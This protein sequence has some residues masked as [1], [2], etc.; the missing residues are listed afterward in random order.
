M[1]PRDFILPVRPSR[2]R[3]DIGGSVFPS[4]GNNRQNSSAEVLPAGCFLLRPAAV[5]CP[6]DFPLPLPLALVT[7]L[8]PCWNVISAAN[9]GSRGVYFGFLLAPE[10]LLKM[11]VEVVHALLRQQASI[12]TA[13]DAESNVSEAFNG[14]EGTN[15]VVILR[16]LATRADEHPHV[17]VFVVDDAGHFPMSPVQH[18][19]H[20]GGIGD[21]LLIDDLDQLVQGP[22]AAPAVV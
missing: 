19:V 3:G 20:Q 4:F 8:P 1:R 5:L 2:V 10:D 18:L 15:A 14:I 16:H 9:A 12:A 17:A 7:E 22:V 21:A 13:R 6:L 11:F